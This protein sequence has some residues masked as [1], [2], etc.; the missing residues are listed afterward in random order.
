MADRMADWS[1]A[2]WVVSMVDQ[3]VVSMAGRLVVSMA[4]WTV[5]WLVVY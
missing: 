5:G 4:V 1:V 3:S 2:A